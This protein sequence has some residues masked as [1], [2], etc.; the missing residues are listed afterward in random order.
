M[1]RVKLADDLIISQI[2]KTGKAFT[3]STDDM[4]CLKIAGA[5]DNVIR[6]MIDTTQPETTDEKV[7]VGPPTQGNVGH[8]TTAQTAVD[9]ERR[10][11]QES[12]AE[13]EGALQRRT[14]VIL[15]IVETVKN[16][17]KQ[18]PVLGELATELVALSSTHN[19]G[20]KMKVNARI[21]NA[22]KRLLLVIE[23]Y[24]ELKSSESFLRQLDELQGTE[25]RIAIERRQYNEAAIHYNTSVCIR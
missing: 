13:V 24:P 17:T 11:V 14:D 4:I 18:E 16:S 23:N 20:E 5:S 9:R 7:Y 22:L 2:R 19:P 10:A 8:S 1:V 3:L 25:N 21:S 12:W 6:A 15:S